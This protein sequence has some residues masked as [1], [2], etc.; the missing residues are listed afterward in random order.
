MSELRQNIATKEWVIIAT[1]RAKRPRDFSRQSHQRTEDRPEWQENC[2]FCPGNEEQSEDVM[3]IPPNGPWH[4]R[5][6]LNKYAALQRDGIRKRTFEGVRR[7]VSGIG[8]HEVII[9]SP[10]HNTCPA[11]QEPGEVALTLKAFQQ[12]G[13]A[14]KKDPNTEH[15]I[16]FKNHGQRAG[17]SLE[18]PHTQ[19]IGLPLVAHHIRNRTEE[20]RR[21]F[22]D[23]GHCVHCQMWSDELEDGR[24]IVA[25]NEDFVAFIP[26]AAFSP[27]HTWIIPRRHAPSFLS[28]DEKEIASLGHILRTVLRKVYVGLG[29]PDYNYVIRSAPF[30]DEEQEYLHWYVTIVPRV[31]RAAGFELG[32]GMFINTALPEESAEFLRGISIDEADG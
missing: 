6:V 1:E 30:R 10:R 16:Y 26:Y 14:I 25:T 22:D 12:R 23:M 9:E 28:I 18:H 15:I 11:L 8:Y 13:E 17:T 7:R 29:D 20:A 3:Q 24:R 32:S 2:P 19:L 21:Y 27:F 4:V 31:T 5:T